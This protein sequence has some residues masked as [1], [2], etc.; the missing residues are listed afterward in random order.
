MHDLRARLLHEPDLFILVMGG[1][2]YFHKQ[3][4]LSGNRFRNV[5]RHSEQQAQPVSGIKKSS[6]GVKCM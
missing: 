4:Y 5:A 2:L 1:I 6:F 3:I